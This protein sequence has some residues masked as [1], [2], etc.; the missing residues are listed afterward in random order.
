M[1]TAI[2]V[3]IQILTKIKKKKIRNKSTQYSYIWT[4]HA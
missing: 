1:Y 3:V 4:A 2:F